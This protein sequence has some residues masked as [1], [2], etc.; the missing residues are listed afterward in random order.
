VIKSR[1]D[2]NE[3]DLFRYW[4]GQKSKHAQTSGDRPV[5]DKVE[6]QSSRPAVV[7][8]YFDDDLAGA[9][10]EKELTRPEIKHVAK[11]VLEALKVLHEDGY[12]HT[13]IVLAQL[14]AG[15]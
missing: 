15:C 1:R 14:F 9:S 4:L 10:A 11:K 2:L 8:K 3:H 6:Y 12:I 7:V 5:I 13:G